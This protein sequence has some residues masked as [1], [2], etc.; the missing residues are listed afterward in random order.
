MLNQAPADPQATQAQALDT[1]A[2][3]S[4]RVYALGLGGKAS[5]AADRSRPTNRGYSE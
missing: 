5:F 1:S 2:P 3:N 4:A